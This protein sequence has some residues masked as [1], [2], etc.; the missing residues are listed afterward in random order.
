M[1]ETAPVIVNSSCLIALSHIGMENVLCKLYN[2]IVVPEGVVKE[3]GEINLG[4]V[5]I[6]KVDNPLVQFLIHQSNLGKGEAEVIALSFSNGMTVILDDQK[7]RGVAKAM[8]VKVT[9][10]IGVI[11]KAKREGLIESAY[12][13]IIELKEKG[14]YVSDD[15]LKDI[16]SE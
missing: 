2:E 15:L 14:F 5:R 3:F 6:Q 8:G 1:P 12:K 4:C 11:L 9:G 10:T 7:A 13:K 16:G